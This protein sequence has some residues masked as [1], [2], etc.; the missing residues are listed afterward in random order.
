MRAINGTD[1]SKPVQC[2]DENTTKNDVRSF[3]RTVGTNAIEIIQQ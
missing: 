3:I 1:T 2:D